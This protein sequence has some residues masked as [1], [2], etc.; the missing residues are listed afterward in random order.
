[1]DIWQKKVCLDT[2]TIFG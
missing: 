1:V 2:T